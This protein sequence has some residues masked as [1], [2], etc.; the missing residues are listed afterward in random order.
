[1]GGTLRDTG[2]SPIGGT[3]DHVHLLVG[4]RGRHAVADVVN[5]VKTGS[6][7]WIKDSFSLPPFGRQDGYAALS[8]GWERKNQ[9]VAYIAGQEEH[10]RN[11]SSKDELEAILVEARIA[12]KRQYFE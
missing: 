2:G 9:L 3:A 10:H 7:K 4:L 8:V 1:M 12:F 6:T 11:W 5:D